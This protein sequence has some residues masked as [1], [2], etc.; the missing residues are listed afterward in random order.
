MCA[1]RT[2]IVMLWKGYGGMVL[3]E[4]YDQAIATMAVR[5]SIS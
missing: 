2:G 5:P 4:G 3:T 1:V